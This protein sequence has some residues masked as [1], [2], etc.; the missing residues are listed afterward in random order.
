[1]WN[2]G[3][4]QRD[5]HFFYDFAVTGSPPALPSKTPPDLVASE[6][7]EID[8]NY[9]TFNVHARCA[10]SLNE[11]P[12]TAAMQLVAEPGSDEHRELEEFFKYGR[13]PDRPIRAKNVTVDMPGGL[14]MNNG[15]AE[16]LMHDAGAPGEPFERRLSILSPTDEVLAS[17][18]LTLYPPVSNHDGTGFSN[19][20]HDSTGVLQIET[21]TTTG[22]PIDMTLRLSRRD[23]AGHYPDKIE[24]ALAVID[25]FRGPNRFRLEPIRGSAGGVGETIPSSIGDDE[26]RDLNRLFLRY[27]RALVVIQRHTPIELKVPAFETLEDLNISNVL[28]AARLLNGETVGIVWKNFQ[29]VLNLGDSFPEGPVSV[30]VAQ[31]LSV[32]VGA[33]Q[34][35]LGHVRFAIEAAQVVDSET[36][37]NGQTVATVEPALGNNAAQLFWLGEASMDH[38]GSDGCD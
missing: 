7:R 1:M 23:I 5:P 6:T 29:M 37:A 8:G 36:D 14:G 38:G 11:R 30:V 2:S 19:R 20:G 31:D 3:L 26:S 4:N 27:I 34:I 22:P 13:T 9:I 35:D 16:V 24:P 33:A 21:L 25:A 12:V 28:R 15:L 10:E 18:D 17:V 32:G